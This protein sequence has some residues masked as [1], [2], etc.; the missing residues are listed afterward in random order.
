M[1]YHIKEFVILLRIMYD[2][3]NF[4]NI[5][6]LGLTY[7]INIFFSNVIKI[8]LMLTS[9]NCSFKQEI[10]YQISNK[11]KFFFLHTNGIILKL[12][13]I[14]AWNKLFVNKKATYFFYI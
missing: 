5:Y 13:Y 3:E 8:E 2:P 7:K 10:L 9:L 4:L 1:P 6:N 11:I 14:P 12:V